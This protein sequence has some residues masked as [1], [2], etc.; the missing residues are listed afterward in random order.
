MLQKITIKRLCFLAILVAMAMVLNLIENALPVA[1]AVPGGK[2]GLAN[3]VAM[4]AFLSCGTP[5]A[6]L[7]GGMRSVL[8]GLLAG[9]PSGI[10]YSLAGTV[11]SICGMWAV[12]RLLG[13][14]VSGVGL[15]VMGAVC[16]NAGQLLIGR[17]LLGSG[18]IWAYLP[19]L[20][21]IGAFAGLITGGAAQLIEQKLNRA[22]G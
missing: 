4:F 11:C 6:L 12:R 16:Y 10:V 19:I 2:L 5:S 14:R 17:L 3:T 8:T 15:S 20:T 7:V 22:T 18:A 9:A 13:S 21:L 1:T